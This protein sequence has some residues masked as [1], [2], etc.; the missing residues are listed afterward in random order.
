[1]VDAGAGDD[2]VVGG[3]GDDEIDGGDGND[4]IIGDD[5]QILRAYSQ[6]GSPKLTSA[7]GWQRE[8]VLENI[9]TVTGVIDMDTTPLRDD[10]ALADLMMQADMLVLAGAFDAGGDGFA[11]PGELI[12]DV[13][14][15]PVMDDAPDGLL[16]LWS[17]DVLS[18]PFIPL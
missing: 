1:M 11:D 14:R 5:G 4:V 7:G 12:T 3:H 13:Y 16:V 2:D 9:A 18:Q 17:E 15:I 6:D 10:S 8:I